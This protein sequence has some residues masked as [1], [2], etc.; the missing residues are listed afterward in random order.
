M[1]HKDASLRR[2]RRL[3]LCIKMASKNTSLLSSILQRWRN[4][5]QSLRFTHLSQLQIF[6]KWSAGLYLSLSLSLS[7]SRARALS[8]CYKMCVFMYTHTHTHTHV[9][10]HA[11]IYMYVCMYVCLCLCLCVYLCVSIYIKDGDTLGGCS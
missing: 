6:E 2:A 11:I 1:L 10:I 4:L 7:L 8:L 5:R 9:Y 3:L